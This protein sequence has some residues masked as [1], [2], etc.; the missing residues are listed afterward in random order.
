MATDWAAELLKAAEELERDLDGV[1][2]EM[3]LSQIDQHAAAVWLLECARKVCN[4]F[5]EVGS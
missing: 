3:T 5:R 2:D 4:P 1:A